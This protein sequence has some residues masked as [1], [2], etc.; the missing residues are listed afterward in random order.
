MKAQRTL[1]LIIVGL[2]I[3]PCAF[4]EHPRSDDRN[5][6]YDDQSRDFRD[7]EDGYSQDRYEREE[8]QS[9][10]SLHDDV[11]DAIARALGRDANAIRVVVRDGR[12]TLSGTVRGE[13]SRSLAHDVAHDVPG[14]RSV[15][16]RGLGYSR[17]R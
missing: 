6:R 14:V 15:S 17:R 3:A 13:R 1:L 9:D 11:H 5:D 12:V 16:V 8:Y 7:Q 10:E 4:A 2:L